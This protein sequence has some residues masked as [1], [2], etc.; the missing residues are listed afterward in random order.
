MVRKTRRKTSCERSSA[1]SRSPSRFVASCTTI[2]WC[3]VTSSAHAASSRAAHRCT[4]VASRTPRSDQLATRACFTRKSR[5]TSPTIA[6]LDTGLIGKFPEGP[7]LSGDTPMRRALFFV[8]AVSLAVAA[9]AGVFEVVRDRD[10]RTQ[11]NRGDEALRGDQVVRAV[12]AYSVAVALR[13]DSMLARLRR[14]EAYQRR[15]DL[16]AALRDFRDA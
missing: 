16:D 14:G 3:S 12:E 8:A 6:K 4:N 11:L 2:R 13:P 15:G 7:I 1:S 10:Y 5:T 9:A